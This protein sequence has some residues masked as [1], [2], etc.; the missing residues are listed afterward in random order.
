MIGSD[1]DKI[2]E[3]HFDSLP[4]RY[5]IGLEKCVKSSDSA[6]YSIYGLFYQC[7]Q[8][9]LNHGISYVGSTEWI[10]N[11]KATINP[12]MAMVIVFRMQ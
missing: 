1:T 2:I 3:G 8:I 9:N 4:Q 5:Q 7:H 11:K 12:K 10:K 6:I